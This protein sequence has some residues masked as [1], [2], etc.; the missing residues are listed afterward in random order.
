MSEVDGISG[1]N[2][3]TADQML[4]NYGEEHLPPNGQPNFVQ[5]LMT[6]VSTGI[7][8][9]M[10]KWE[11]GPNELVP[12]FMASDEDINAALT[13]VLSRPAEPKILH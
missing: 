12:S 11:N 4:F 3:N 13:K 7:S 2:L 10:Q 6:N 1:S 9:F 5:S 8:S